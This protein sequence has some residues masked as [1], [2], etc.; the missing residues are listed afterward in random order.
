MALQDVRYAADASATSAIAIT[1]GSTK[2]RNK[3]LELDYAGLADA[4]NKGVAL[5]P[6]LFSN[7][8]TDNADLASCA[9]SAAR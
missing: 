8:I 4:M 5:Q 1:N 9:T 7:L 3:W 6:E 2:E